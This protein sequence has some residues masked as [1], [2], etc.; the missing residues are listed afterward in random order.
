MIVF[1]DIGANFVLY[2]VGFTTSNFIVYEISSFIDLSLRSK[3][4][5]D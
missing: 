3:A 4:K 2:Q 5:L 1:D